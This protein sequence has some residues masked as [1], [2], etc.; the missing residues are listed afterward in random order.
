MFIV[1]KL[2]LT[3][4]LHCTDRRKIPLS[5]RS[6]VR[7]N[8]GFKLGGKPYGIREQ[9]QPLKL[10]KNEKKLH[11]EEGKKNQNIQW[12]LVRDT[13]Y[14]DNELY[15]DLYCCIYWWWRCKWS[16][17]DNTPIWWVYHSIR[18]YPTIKDSDKDHLFVSH[19]QMTRHC[20]TY[21]SWWCR[22][23]N[24]VENRCW[25]KSR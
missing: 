22:R 11:S 23:T 2:W 18:W 15:S 1:F 25:W 8:N 16:S 24:R 10:N 20:L 5:Q 13:L 12:T 6:A 4:G 19:L 3:T 7:F 21:R 9:P 14:I 17:G